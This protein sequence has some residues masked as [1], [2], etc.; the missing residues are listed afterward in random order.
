MNN[1]EPADYVF[2]STNQGP[3][4]DMDR[5]ERSLLFAEL[6]KVSYYEPDHA[7]QILRDAGVTQFEFFERDGAQ[8]YHFENATDSVIVCRGT[9]PD[10]IND[11]KADVNALAVTAETVGRVHRG[12]KSECDDLWPMIEEA[13]QNNEKPV[14]FAGHSL[15]GAMSTICAGRC[16]VS[17][18]KAMPK[19]LYT[20]GSPRVGDKRYINFCDIEHVRWVN[21]NDIVPRLPP[22]WMG[23]NHSGKEMYI[24]RRGRLRKISGFSRTLDRLQGFGESLL[25]LQIDQLSDH[26]I[27]AYIDALDGITCRYHGKNNDDE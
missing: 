12:F 15:G 1:P 6:S 4:S 11:V 23:Y 17:E 18:I 24:N 19:G 13:M 16:F 9:E 7:E 2:R 14:W 21:N 5:L 20:Y 3:I 26:S 25:K 27:D 8:A 22:R 10:D